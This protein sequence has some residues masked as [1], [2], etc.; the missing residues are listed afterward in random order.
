[1][2]GPRGE[3]GGECG[4]ARGNMMTGCTRQKEQHVGQPNGKGYMQGISPGSEPSSRE[5]EAGKVP[6]GVSHMTLEESHTAYLSC[7]KRKASAPGVPQ[8][9]ALK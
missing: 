6:R 8:A 3:Q 9:Q 4:G 2:G 1:M 5:Q 7:F